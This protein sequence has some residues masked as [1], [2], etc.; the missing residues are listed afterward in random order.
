MWVLEK[1]KEIDV[2][3]ERLS[4]FAAS[5]FAELVWTRE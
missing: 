5:G 3:Q 1:L 4:T 2:I